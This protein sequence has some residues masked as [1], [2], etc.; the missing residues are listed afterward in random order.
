MTGVT[1]WMKLKADF[2]LTVS[3][4]SHCA[5]LMRIIRPSFV[6]PALFTRISI[7][8]NSSTIRFTTSCVCSKSAAFEA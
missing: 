2:R 6:I 3:T 1:A 5:S 8:P 4:A 7:R